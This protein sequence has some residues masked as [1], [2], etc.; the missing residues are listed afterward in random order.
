MAINMTTTYQHFFSRIFQGPNQ[1]Q[2]ATE[3]AQKCKTQTGGEYPVTTCFDT[4]SVDMTTWPPDVMFGD[5]FE[6][7]ITDYNLAIID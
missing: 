1:Q 4:T 2:I 7:F 6:K 3:F 5:W